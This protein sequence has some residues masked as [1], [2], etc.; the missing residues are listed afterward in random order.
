MMRHHIGLRPWTT[1][2]ALLLL[3]TTTAGSAAADV[4]T[5]ICLI[6]YGRFTVHDGEVYWYSSCTTTMVGNDTY[7]SCYYKPGSEIWNET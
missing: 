7:Y 3:L 1:I 4:C 2:V 5:T 6:Y